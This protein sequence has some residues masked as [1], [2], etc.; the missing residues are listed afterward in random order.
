MISTTIATQTLK[1][2]TGHETPDHASKPGGR[3]DFFP[4][5]RAYFDCVPCYDAFPSGH[6]AVGSMT[7]TVIAKNYPDNPWIVPVGSTLL[8]MLSFQMMNNGVHW[9]S[10][11][12]LAIALGYTFGTMAYERGLRESNA[13]GSG[14]VVNN[15]IQWT[16][17]LLPEGLGLAMRYDF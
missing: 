12:P 11:Y 7:L 14:A 13:M 6:L 16:P 4:N 10:D 8:S 1:H 17:L 2:I 9:A 5:Q 15:A 3:W